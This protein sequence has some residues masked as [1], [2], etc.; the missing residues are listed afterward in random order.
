[1]LFSDKTNLF[2]K[3]FRESGEERKRERGGRGGDCMATFLRACY[4]TQTDLL[5]ETEQTLFIVA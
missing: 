3:A 2:S 1:M 5:I 4:F